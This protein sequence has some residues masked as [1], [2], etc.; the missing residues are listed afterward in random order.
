L[1]IA[2]FH[3]VKLTLTGN[4]MWSMHNCCNSM[5]RPQSLMALIVVAMTW[6]VHSAPLNLIPLPAMVKSL[7]GQFSLD[8]NTVIVADDPFTNEAA[9]LAGQWQLSRATSATNNRVLLT[10]QNAGQLGEEA[11]RLEVDQQGVIIRAHAAAGAFYGCQTLLQLKPA[12]S[13]EI[14]FVAIEDAPRYVWRGFLLDVSRHFFDVSTVCQLIDWMAGYKLNRLHLH[15]TDDQAWRLQIDQY[16]ELTQVGAR[17]NYS[18]TPSH[19]DTNKP[20]LFFTRADLQKIIAYATQRHIVVVPEIDMPGH[21]GAAIRAFPRLDGGLNTYNPAREET[22][23]F[24]QNVLLT[25][26]EIFP[27]PWIHFGG[28]EVNRSGWNIRADVKQKLQAAGLKETSELENQFATRMEKFILAHGHTPMG[29]DEIVAGKPEPGT[30]IFW[31]RHDKPESLKQALAGGY[32]VVLTPRS[33]CYFDYPQNASYPK[34]GWK[35]VNTAEQVYAGPTIPE[36]IPAAQRQHILGVEGCLWTERIATVSYL[37][38]MTLP[39]LAALSE[40]AWTPEAEHDYAQFNER[41]KPFLSQYQKQG[42]FY[43][44]ATDPANSF[45]EAHE[46]QTDASPALALKPATGIKEEVFQE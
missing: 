34:A 3:S 37:Q 43:Y 40:M 27:S 21:G 18:N 32:S 15:L 14:P 5:L 33:P 39:R 16:P 41:L 12:D 38:F 13:R 22:Y 29:W 24:L 17:G 19:L 4:V 46:S 8:S 31:W 20:A 44:D 36:E 26:M 11:Y 2:K 7:P 23:N 42:I 45:R 35:L 6:V 25:T 30:V 1:K 9:L 10:T 28:D